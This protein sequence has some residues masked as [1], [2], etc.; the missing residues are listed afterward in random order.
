MLD[1]TQYPNI[2]LPLASLITGTIGSWILLKPKITQRNEYIEEL[3]GAH[4]Q[5]A[6]YLRSI[7]TRS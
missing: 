6:R 4:A 7:E 5:R 3:E 1:I 2:R